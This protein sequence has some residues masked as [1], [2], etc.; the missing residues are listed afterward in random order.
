MHQKQKKKIPQNYFLR[1]E[2]IVGD[3]ST[4]LY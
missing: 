3:F 2:K 1:S 4:N